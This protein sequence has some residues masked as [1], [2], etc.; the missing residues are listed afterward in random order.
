MN[1]VK[2]EIGL[3]YLRD[4]NSMK[5]QIESTCDDSSN[6]TTIPTAVINF[7]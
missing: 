3:A 1:R 2:P 6:E 5:Q 7:D 4:N